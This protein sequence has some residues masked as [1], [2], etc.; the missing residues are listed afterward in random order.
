[1]SDTFKEVQKAAADYKRR[2]AGV[3][4]L[5]DGK[6]VK[7]KL[8]G[9]TFYVTRKL[10]GV[11]AYAVCRGGKVTMVG[12]GGRD[13]SEVPC[14]KALAAAVK[15]Y[16]AKSATV[17]AELYA[18]TKSGRPRVYDVLAALADPNKAESLRLAPFD[19][20]ELDGEPFKAGYKDVHAKLAAIFKDDAVKPV[21][22]RTASGDAEV[23]DIYGEWVVDGGAEGLVVRSEMPIVWKV[24][25]RHTV[26]AAVVGFTTGEQG[27][28][29]LMFAVRHDDG[30]YQVFA[31]AGN[32]LGE[33]LRASLAKTLSKKAVE[34]SFV[35]TDS[36]GIAFQMVRP[37]MVYEVSVGD[38]I[39]E[40]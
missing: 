36:R 7:A 34:S 35:Q 2:V 10:D 32:G 6:D 12:S 17:V 8:S 22:M 29:D 28:R 19:L 30:R 20:V 5:V 26:D 14:A 4:M 27:V 31:V 15:A 9:E 25:P 38:L 33:K 13:L 1:M 23:E 18:P 11:M 39:A 3:F 40:D 16:G 37:E 24:K 21:E